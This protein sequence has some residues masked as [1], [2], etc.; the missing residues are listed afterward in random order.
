MTIEPYQMCFGLTTQLDKES[1]SCFLQLA[2]RKEFADVFADRLSSAEIEIF[3]N[4]FMVLL[5]RHLS[6]DDYHR[7]FLKDNAPHHQST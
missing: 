5:R 2:G 4:S 3:V 6:E 1:F 7:L